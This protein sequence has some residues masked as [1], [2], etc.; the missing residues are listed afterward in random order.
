MLQIELIFNRIIV[1]RVSVT[2]PVDQNALFS[3][4]DSSSWPEITSR[5]NHGQ[6]HQ[7]RDC[8]STG[9]DMRDDLSIHYIQ[10]WVI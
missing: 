3:P 8:F 5:D 1:L 7:L 2:P 9:E 10:L 6:Y 4:Y